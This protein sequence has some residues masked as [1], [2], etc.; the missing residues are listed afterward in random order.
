M[1]DDARA[2]FDAHADDWVDYNRQPLGLIRSE[3]TWHNLSHHLPPIADA[4]DPPRVLDAG[5]GSGELALRLV[6]AGYRVWLLDYAPAM[7]DRAR[8][9]ARELPAEARDRLAYC[10]MPAREAGEAFDP[11]FF[12]VITCHTLIEYLP[13]PQDT[14]RKLAHV[15][16]DGGLL[17]LSFVNRRYKV[18]RQ[19]LRDGAPTG[20]LA[21]REKG[22]FCARLFGVPGRAYTIDEIRRWLDDLGLGI[23][24]IYGVR[25]FADDLLACC[26]ND[27]ELLA[28][29]LQVELSSAS[30]DSLYH[31][32][33]YIHLIAHLPGPL[34][35]GEEGQ[36]EEAFWD[37]ADL[38]PPAPPQGREASPLAPGGEG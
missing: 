1:R 22:Q 28:T 9:A 13:Q 29:L 35:P 25:I 11:A 27:P 34:A 16:S 7:L 15:L 2:R 37:G 24:A 12:D 17:S 20:A 5:G 32:A 21:R 33:R 19:M 6:R 38:T 18:L 4:A 3:V 10:L 30:V 26:P 8:Q 31:I 23:A 14:L 36:G